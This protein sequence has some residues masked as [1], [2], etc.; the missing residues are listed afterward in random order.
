MRKIFIKDIF[1]ILLLSLIH[2]LKNQLS[3]IRLADGPPFS[4]ERNEENVFSSLPTIPYY[5]KFVRIFYKK[6]TGLPFVRN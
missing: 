4:P 1:N 6:Q 5:W 3:P 2:T